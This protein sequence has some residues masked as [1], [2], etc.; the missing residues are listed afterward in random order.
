MQKTDFLTPIDLEKQEHLSEIRLANVRSPYCRFDVSNRPTANFIDLM[1]WTEETFKSKLKDGQ[2]LNKFVHNRI[3]IDGQFLQ[4]C[5][6]SKITVEC[7][8]KDSVISWKTDHGF[9][10]FF[11][12]GVFLIKSKDMEFLHA[13]LF[14]KGNQNE[15]EIS[16]FVIVSDSNYTAYVKLRNS[17]DEWVQQ[18]DRSNLHIRVIEGEDMPYTK[19]HTWADLFLPKEIKDQLQALVENFLD[20]KDFYLKNRIPWKRGI[21][22]YGKPG[23][24]KTSIIRTVMSQYNFKPVTIVP[25]ANDDAVREAFSYAEEQSPSLLYFEDLDSLL[26][27]SVDISSFLNLMDGISTKNGLLIIATAND[28]K[29]LK[30]NITDRPSRF[31]RKFEIPL[32]NREM[33]YIYLKRWFGNLLSAKKCKELSRYAEKYDF[34]YAYLKE[35]YISSMFEAL[36]HNRK[37]PTE[38]DIENA[39]NRLVKDKNILNNGKTIN[40][41]KYFK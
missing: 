12:Q 4:F 41:D 24:G 15:D 29:K 28:V 9:E 18:R 37:A 19:D 14:H 25:G 5:E 21:L 36:S 17:F 7:L 23:N 35:L 3:I 27:K 8:H 13:A 32:P 22:L 39:L 30:P 6:E 11:V 38:K 2:N 40:T 1:N 20:S 34:S 16:F 31:D 26:E 10:K 33:A